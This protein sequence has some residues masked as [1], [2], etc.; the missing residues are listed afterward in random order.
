MVALITVGEQGQVYFHQQG[1]ISAWFPVTVV[2]ITRLFGDRQPAAKFASD[3]IHSHGGLSRETPGLLIKVTEHASG[4]KLEHRP[5]W[6]PV[7]F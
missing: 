4:S 2:W 6:N 3:V 7:H 1:V 5:G